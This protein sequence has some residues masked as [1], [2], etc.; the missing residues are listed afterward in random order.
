MTVD[1]G[2]WERASKQASKQ[3]SEGN[4]DW[5]DKGKARSNERH[6][7]AKAEKRHTKL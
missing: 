2:Q 7:D 1:S 5:I 4:L 6:R 3:A